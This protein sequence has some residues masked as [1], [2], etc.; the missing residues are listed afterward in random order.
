[1]Q[2]DDTD[3]TLGRADPTSAASPQETNSET[4]SREANPRPTEQ[5]QPT[6]HG[7]S[8]EYLWLDSTS[9]PT[10][11]GHGLSSSSSSPDL[12]DA[13]SGMEVDSAVSGSALSALINDTKPCSP[14]PRIATRILRW[15]RIQG[16]QTAQSHFGRKDTLHAD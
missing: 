3:S 5:N 8:H 9:D 12:M 7:Q 4:T 16:E 13:G 11:E 1:M 14:S 6:G 10:Y 2:T 15:A